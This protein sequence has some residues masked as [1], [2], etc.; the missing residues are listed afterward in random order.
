MLDSGIGESPLR[1]FGKHVQRECFAV[2]ERR[3]DGLDGLTALFGAGG[4]DSARVG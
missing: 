2:I 4:Q 3:F 1:V